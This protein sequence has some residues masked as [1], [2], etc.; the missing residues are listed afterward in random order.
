[1][2]TATRGLRIEIVSMLGLIPTS[3]TVWGLRIEKNSY[4]APV[5]FSIFNNSLNNTTSQKLGG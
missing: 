1:M 2:C 4:K 5:F 3:S